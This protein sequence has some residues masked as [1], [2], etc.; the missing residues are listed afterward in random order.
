MKVLTQ[1]EKNV[2]GG[3]MINIFAAYKEGLRLA[4]N[5][6][7]MLFWLY[8][9]NLM[10]AY[11]LTIPVSMILTAA[12]D[13]TTAAD[14][15]L[16]AFDITIFSTI[17]LTYGK[18]ITL[19]RGVI[20]IGL[21]YLLMN[22]FFSGGILAV[23]VTGDRFKLSEFLSN[24]ILYFK[25]FLRLFLFSIVFFIFILII[26]YL[27]SKICGIFTENSVTEHA[28]VYLLIFRMIIVGFLLMMV[29]M[30][31]DYAKIMT[32]VNDFHRMYKTV[33]EAIIF[34]R[35][36][37]LKT[38]GLYFLYLI[39]AI[40]FLV[41]YLFVESWLHISNGWLV[42]IFFIWSQLYMISKIWIRLSFYGG[43][44]IFYRSSNTAM[45]GM[46]KEMLDSAVKDY[47]KK[48]AD[49]LEK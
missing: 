29:I 46:T 22:I 14:K 21:V 43:Q 35:M 17:F 11:L 9:F 33:K 5:D 41:A 6:K 27:L 13:Q 36:N 31:F 24:C 45:P 40:I 30:I 37:F 10:F 15:V 19:S 7:K 39:T 32:I 49:K 38:T 47:E 28:Y 8:G 12:L 2:T 1:F 42:L 4:W 16:E 20:T 34:I 48:I 23:F 18:G 44:Y 26:N 25:R 3:K